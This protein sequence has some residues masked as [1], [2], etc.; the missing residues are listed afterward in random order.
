[1]L[2]VTEAEVRRI[3][4][5]TIGP[6][7]GFISRRCGG[8]RALAEDIAQ[9]TWLRAVRT[10]R[11]NGVPE[12]PAAWLNTVARNL[13]L[14]HFRGVTPLPLDDVGTAALE[15][16]PEPDPEGPDPVAVIED[17]LAGMPAESS[18]LL[19]KFHLERRRVA[20]IAEETGLSERAVEGRL[21][22]GR[23]KLKRLIEAA[24]H[25]RGGAL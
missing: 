16:A 25:T 22:R 8:D 18:G 5:E 7:Y 4:R 3:Y 14:N 15:A 17:G 19:R 21:K 12:R 11:R 20:E 13:L 23:E 2:E 9:E 1:M 10:W 24:M 6:L